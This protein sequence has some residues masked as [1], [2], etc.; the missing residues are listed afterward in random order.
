VTG[1]VNLGNPHEITVREL[2]ERV[3]AMTGAG[4]KIVHRPLPQDDPL[5]RCPDIGMARSLLGWAPSVGLED[6]LART[7]GYFRALLAEG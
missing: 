5:Q 1:P 7:I 3:I 4:S 2:A 6:G